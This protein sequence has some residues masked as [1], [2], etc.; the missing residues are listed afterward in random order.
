MS[1]GCPHGSHPSYCVECLEGPPPER[2]K[3]KWAWATRPFTAGYD[4]SCSGC[5]KPITA[6]ESSIVRWER[7]A[8]VDTEQTY[9]HEECWP[10][11]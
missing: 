5:D 11:G 4:G 8:G 1:A 9:T 6:G 7:D 3:P 2:P 10:R